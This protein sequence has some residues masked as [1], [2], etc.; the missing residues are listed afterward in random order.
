MILLDIMITQLRE[1]VPPVDASGNIIEIT[2]T[3][4]LD[5]NRTMC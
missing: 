2:W 4:G 3:S 5:K 1:D